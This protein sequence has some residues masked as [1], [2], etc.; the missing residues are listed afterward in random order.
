[1]IKNSN[2]YTDLKK[3][4]ITGKIYS[5]F[6]LYPRLRKL[7]HGNLLDYG[8][9]VGN[10]TNYYKNFY[11]VTPAET[12]LDCINYVKNLGLNP[13]TIKNDHVSV[14][15]NFFDSAILDNVLEHVS[16]VSKVIAEVTRVV[17]K[18]GTIVIGIPGVLGFNTHWDHKS[19][20][21]EIE[22]NKLCKNF[23]LALE[24]VIYTPFIKSEFLSLHMRQYCIY[25]QIENKK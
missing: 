13:I 8:A 24:K 17:K 4:R 25:A 7:L 6:F 21:D 16:N 10:F 1:M 15:D 11:K 14:H 2:I 18:N 3:K 19:F 12:N 23:N 20:F 22:I 5:N 9:G